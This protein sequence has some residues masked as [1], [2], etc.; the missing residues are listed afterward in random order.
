MESDRISG[1]HGRYRIA[2]LKVRIEVP[3]ALAEQL[4]KNYLDA[5]E[6]EPDITLDVPAERKLMR[7]K[8]RIDGSDEFDYLDLG[9]I[10]YR[11]LLDFDGLYLHASAI[12]MDGK[13]YLITAPPG[14]GKSTHTRLWLQHFGQDR[15]VIINDDSPA[16][17]WVDGAFHAF[18]TPWSGGTR[19]NTNLSAPVQGIA[20]IQR[21]EKNSIALALMNECI[22]M[23]LSQTLFRGDLARLARFLDLVERL[24]TQVPIY[25]LAC[26]MEPS[27]AA[28]AHRVMSEAKTAA[29]EK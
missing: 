29:Q 3:S 20:L 19:I 15:A 8:D 16:L 12:V 5:F 17:R 14:T 25:N 11:K 9:K 27:A 1:R 10:F 18:G 21:A 13:A 24:V 22:P 6:G 23:L 2:G 4:G 26:N 7:P 28:L